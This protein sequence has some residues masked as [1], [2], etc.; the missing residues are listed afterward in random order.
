[1]PYI[2]LSTVISKRNSV[3]GLNVPKSDLEGVKGKIH[4]MKGAVILLF[5]TIVVK[6]IAKLMTHSKHMNVVVEPVMRYS[7]LVAMARSYGA[8][9]PGRGKIDFCLRN[10]SAK[11]ITLPKQTTVREI[12]AANVI[13][14]LLVLKPTGHESSKGKA[15]T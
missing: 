11:Q 15:T 2:T 3:K 13:L 12:A 9:K 5:V 14:A 6:G 1:M 10:H 8:L 7:D 4:T